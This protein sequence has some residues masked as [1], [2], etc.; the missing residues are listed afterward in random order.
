M[1]GRS[2]VSSSE[3]ESGA[4]LL[5]VLLRSLAVALAV[6]MG[7]RAS[8]KPDSESAWLGVRLLAL[9]SLVLPSLVL[10]AVVV[11]VVLLLVPQ[12]LGFVASMAA[13]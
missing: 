4:A 7:S 2:A 9:P 6:S 13:K 1:L 8:S 12:E 11:E 10:L 5:V 3:S